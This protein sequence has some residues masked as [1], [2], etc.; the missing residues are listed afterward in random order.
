M[1]CHFCKML[2]E[3]DYDYYYCIGGHGF[4]LTDG[5]NNIISYKLYLQ[6][7]NVSYQLIGDLE[8]TSLYI[9]SN[10]DN[11]SLFSRYDFNIILSINYIPILIKEDVIQLDMALINRLKKIVVFS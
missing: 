11:E 4:I 1:R 10:E 7:K 9:G 2:L 6:Q 5:Y 3:E 8:K